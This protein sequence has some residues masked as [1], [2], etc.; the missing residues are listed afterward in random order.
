M[1]LQFGYILNQV[2]P[3]IV[4]HRDEHVDLQLETG[5]RVN[6]SNCEIDLL[7]T[8]RFEK[9][10]HR[11]AVELKCYKTFASS[12]GKRGATDIFMKD[13]YEDLELLERYIDHNL[14]DAGIALVMT[15]LERFVKP[16]TKDAKCWTYDISH[17]TAFVGPVTLDTPIGGKSVS[18]RLKKKYLFEWIQ[19]GSFWFLEVEGAA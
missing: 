6:S 18:I 17:G 5:V 4:F 12:G 14:A 10:Q 2:L 19:Y 15:D 1:Q 13:V 9:Q 8:G 11:I 16:K 3:L 7:L